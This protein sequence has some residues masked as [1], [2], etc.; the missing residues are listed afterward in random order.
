MNKLIMEKIY[1]PVV[2]FFLLPLFSLILGSIFALQYN[3]LNYLSLIALYV[4][5]VIN[6]LIEN[7]LLRKPKANFELSKKFLILLELIN[8]LFIFFFSIRHSWIAGIILFLYTF[9][10]QFQF[11][12]SYYELEK[13]AA[14]LVNFFKIILLN[15]FSFYIHTNFVNYRFVPYYLAIFIPFLIYELARLDEKPSTKMSVIIIS[16]SYLFAII[17]LWGSLH[18]LSFLLL[19]TLPVSF[20]LKEEFNLIYSASFSIIFSVVFVFLTSYSLIK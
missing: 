9:T 10:I 3:S 20:V 15:G 2:Y 5:I 12:F 18:Y 14:F 17:L 6:Q 4:Y 7:I 8:F 11:L 1:H 19:L 16:L 13:M